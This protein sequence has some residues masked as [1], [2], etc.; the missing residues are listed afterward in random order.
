MDR[1]TSRSLLIVGAVCFGISTAY[2]LLKRGYKDI[3]VL[4]R[5]GVL[6]APDAASTDLSTSSYHFYVND[7]S[8]NTLF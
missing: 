6:P 5:S 7:I 8:A 1:D 4:D 3:T 2:H